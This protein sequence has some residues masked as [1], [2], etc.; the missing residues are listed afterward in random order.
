MT[1]SSGGEL[2]EWRRSRGWD[3]AELAWQLGRDATNR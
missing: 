3:V 2:R 1:G